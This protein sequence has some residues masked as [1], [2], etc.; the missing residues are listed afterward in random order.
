MKLFF[1]IENFSRE[2]KLDI[3][4]NSETYF[5]ILRLTYNSKTH[6]IDISSEMAY[7][8]LYLHNFTSS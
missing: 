2:K 7:N 5:I 1:E 4:L 6:F 3:S 8:S